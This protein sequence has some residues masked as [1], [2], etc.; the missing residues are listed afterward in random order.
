MRKTKYFILLTCLTL[1]NYFPI[2][3]ILAATK[4]PIPTAIEQAPTKRDE[5]PVY[6]I[7]PIEEEIRKKLK[8]YVA[9]AKTK[10]LIDLMLAEM[11]SNTKIYNE[12]C[13]FSFRIR[14]LEMYI[15][16]GL[17]STMDA[18]LLYNQIADGFLTL[19][20]EVQLKDFM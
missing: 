13:H 18:T 12:I 1:F 15:R 11:Y 10:E 17:I 9:A 7:L 14:Y 6:D 8:A 3:S 2:N 16:K 19:I 5:I 4:N 20:D